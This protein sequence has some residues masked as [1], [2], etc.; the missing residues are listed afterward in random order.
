MNDWNEVCICRNNPCAPEFAC[1]CGASI[2]FLCNNCVMAHLREPKAHSFISLDQ[3]RK[4]KSS[5]QDFNRQLIESNRKFIE[6]KMQVQAYLPQITSFISQI[7]EFRRSILHT[8]NQ[9]CDSKIETLRRIETDVVL[10]VEI[11]NQ[12]IANSDFGLL[13]KFDNN[14]LRGI[15]EYYPTVFDL[16]DSG[17]VENIENTIYI[18]HSTRVTI[19]KTKECTT[20]DIYQELSQLRGSNSE[21]MSKI[22]K[23]EQSEKGHNETILKFE[24]EMKKYK[25]EKE[26]HIID[27]THYLHLESQNNIKINEYEAKIE[28]LKQEISFLKASNKVSNDQITDYSSNLSNL[29]SYITD[30]KPLTPSHPSNMPTKRARKNNRSYDLE[31]EEEKSLTLSSLVSST[32]PLKNTIDSN[33]YLYFTKCN[34]KLIY[35]YN[36]DTNQVNSYNISKN[37]KQ[38]F[39]KTS[40][41][42]LPDG[43]I[44][45]AGG[46]NPSRKTVIKFDPITLASTTVGN[47]HTARG[48]ITLVPCDSFVYAFG[49]QADLSKEPLNKAERMVADR[50]EWVKLD[51]MHYARSEC[52]YYIRDGRIYLIGGESNNTVECFNT[53]NCM[54]IKVMNMKLPIDRNIVWSAGNSVYIFSKD[55][56][57]TLSQDLILMNCHVMNESLHEFVLSNTVGRRDS[58]FFYCNSNSKI[59]SINYVRNQVKVVKDMN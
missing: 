21:Y 50:T 12:N 22:E 45:I 47:L 39:S 56:Q 2:V 1:N 58:V 29:Q 54:F 28:T 10:K 13:E 7:E 4:I 43:S 44:L 59:Y 19:N 33:T 20:Q 3:A 25:E 37:T 6:L 15:L 42:V 9:E 26:Q 30:S 11:I 5:D 40:S 16:S 46:C 35:Q 14:G 52:G 49:G 27:I 51:D 36:P 32:I 34:T 24:S 17:I 23:Y 31:E 53:Y 41:C 48:C 38:F 18:G 8:I 57:L 55:R